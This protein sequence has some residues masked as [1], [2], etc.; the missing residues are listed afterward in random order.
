MPPPGALPLFAVLIAV[1][2]TVSSP[3][4]AAEQHVLIERFAKCVGPTGLRRELPPAAEY[5][6]RSASSQVIELSAPGIV[7]DG[8][9]HTLILDE[10]EG[11]A[12]IVQTGGIAGTR[13]VFGPLSVERGCADLPAEGDSPFTSATAVR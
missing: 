1:A 13:A 4:E 12:F 7:A 10:A 5:P 9:A 6:A 11:V 8:Y 3:A 2:G